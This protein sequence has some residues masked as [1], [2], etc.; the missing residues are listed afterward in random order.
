MTLKLLLHQPT[1]TQIGLSVS[2]LVIVA[3]VLSFNLIYF[4]I[5]FKTGIFK[6]L[7]CAKGNKKKKR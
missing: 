3:V 4:I 5:I 1:Q 6:A 7:L 2:V